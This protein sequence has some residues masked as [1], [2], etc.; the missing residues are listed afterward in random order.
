MIAQLD[1]HTIG[2]EL[3]ALTLAV[4]LVCWP[5]QMNASS[6]RVASQRNRPPALCSSECRCSET[7]ERRAARG[8]PERLE[9]RDHETLDH[10]AKMMAKGHSKYR[11][12]RPRV[13]LFPSMCPFAMECTRQTSIRLEGVPYVM[14]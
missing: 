6:L 8:C 12:P 1:A 14:L 10:G 11:F 9:L 3:P 7:L 5:V 13:A 2:I 4:V